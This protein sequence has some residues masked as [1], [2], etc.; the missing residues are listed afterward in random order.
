MVCRSEKYQDI[1]FN[2]F[3]VI[4]SLWFYYRPHLHPW[5][6]I[7]LMLHT[8]NDAPDAMRSHPFFYPKAKDK[9]YY[10]IKLRKKILN[11]QSTKKEP[12]W[13]SSYETCQDLKDCYTIVEKYNCSTPYLYSGAHMD[14]LCYAK[15]KFLGLII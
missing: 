14:L 11:K 6:W 13:E 4:P 2:Q 3:D 7:T 1:D 12:C 5:T 15:C 8:Q 10:S 9:K